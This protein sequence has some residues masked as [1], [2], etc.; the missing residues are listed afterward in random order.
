M[1]E[2]YR[3]RPPFQVC[4]NRIYLRTG[5]GSRLLVP[6]RIGIRMRKTLV[7]LLASVSLQSAHAEPVWIQVRQS[8]IRAEP[9]FYA[10]SVGAVK[11]GDRLNKVSQST[12]WIQ[13]QGPGSAGYVPLSVVSDEQ[14]VLSS[15]DLSK[16]RADSGE[17]V[18]AGKGFSKEVEQSYKKRDKQLRYDL[19]DFVERSTLVTPPEVF[20]F[21]KKG[22]LK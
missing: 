19:V 14:I 12:G 18:L 22:G 21:M 3:G 6:V 9:K 5:M 16:V 1:P 20:Q 2:S 13:V 8:Q 4:S 10:K 11:F 15:A 17:V 7:V